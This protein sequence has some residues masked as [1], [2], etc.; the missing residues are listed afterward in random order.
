MAADYRRNSKNKYAEKAA[1]R[2][3]CIC[4]LLQLVGYRIFYL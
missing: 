3:A 1:Q 4:G 2:A